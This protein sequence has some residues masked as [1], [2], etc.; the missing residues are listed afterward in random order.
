MTLEATIIRTEPDTVYQGTVYD[1]TVVVELPNGIRFG[2]FDPDLVVDSKFI[3]RNVQL[4]VTVLAHEG[5]IER[6]TDGIGEINPLKDDPLFWRDHVYVGKIRDILSW[7]ENRREIQLD[8]GD[9]TII[10]RPKQ[11]MI[12]E[13]REGD[14][15]RIKASRSDVTGIE[16]Q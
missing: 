9:G 8:I 2:L 13:L 7:S 5:G 12:G 6:I 4:T 14:Q 1:Q 16:I 10:V 3:G 15:L 11:D